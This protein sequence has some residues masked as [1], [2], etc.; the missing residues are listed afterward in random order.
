MEGKVVARVGDHLFTE[1]DIDAEFAR[2]P[3]SFRRMK[4]NPAM[5]ANILNNLMTRYALA[6]EARRMG[7]A[8]DPAVRRRIESTRTSILLQELNRRQRAR[9]TPRD[10]K[11]LRAYYE[12]NA[13]RFSHPER[14]HLRHIL[15]KSKKEAERILRK[16][17]K[18]A[19]FADLAKKY[20]E[21]KG[22]R[23]RG[24][25]LGEI[26]R[27]RMA[28][29]V[30]QAAFA[31]EKDGAIAGPVKSRFGYHIIQRL[32]RTPAGRIPFAQVKE[33]IRRELEQQAF[34]RWVEQV[35]Q[36]LGVTVL[37]PRYQRG[38]HTPGARPAS[39]W[40]RSP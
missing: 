8:D 11:A 28:P 17:R 13:A 40:H 27:G 38:P 25:D 39:P 4:A 34:R 19:D 14:L 12:A 23:A 6:E 32:G 16:L 21:G 5:R 9:L 33:R 31:L 3:A 22:S 15:V 35:R 30:E 7:I 29:E 37:D 24:G 2:M 36:K 18:G 10:E 26:T 20:S 1:K